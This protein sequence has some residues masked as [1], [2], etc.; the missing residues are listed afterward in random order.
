MWARSGR[1]LFYRKGDRMMAVDVRTS[2]TFKAGAP[3]VL[4]QGQYA[5]LVWG[6][7]DYD[8]SADGQR[9]LMVKGEAQSSPTELQV[10]MNSFAELK[11]K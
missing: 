6:E 2:P 11:K 8:V 10:V 4:F 7:A 1:E 3:R 5:R 9:F